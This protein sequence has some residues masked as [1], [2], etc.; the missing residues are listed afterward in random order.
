MKFILLVALILALIFP[1]TRCI[2]LHI[3]F[4][5]FHRAKDVYEYFFKYKINEAKNLGIKMYV[6]ALDHSQ[7]F[8][9]GKTLSAVILVKKYFKKYNNKTILV[10]GAKKKQKIIVFS[11]ID[12]KGIPTVP[13]TSFEQ[14]NGW[15]DMKKELD[16]NNPDCFHV[17]LFFLDEAG[18]IMSHRAYAS[19]FKPQQINTLLTSRHT[20]IKGLVLT[21]QDFSLTDKLIREITQEVVSCKMCALLPHKKRVLINTTYSAAELENCLDPT[22]LQH[23]R[24]RCIYVFDK[25][26]GCYD[27][28]AL[29][30]LVA[31][32]KNF[33]TAE[34]TLRALDLH[35]KNLGQE[36]SLK[37]KYRKQIMKK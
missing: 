7:V 31:H 20:Y 28:M 29:V 12:L 3:P 23:I 22:L 16:E 37:R 30:D 10:N 13:F 9:S 8:G 11:N 17:C 21:N 25:W 24:Q 18:V 19:T 34:E 15:V 4:Y 6:S 35:E 5:I 33:M 36:F 1:I 14:L 2:L 26:Y 32:D 27:T